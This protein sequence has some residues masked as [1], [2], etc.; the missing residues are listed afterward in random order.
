MAVF[1]R[2]VS[3]LCRPVQVA[4]S[5]IQDSVHF[6]KDLEAAQTNKRSFID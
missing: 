4:V 3:S 1:L 5:H 2:H 6:N